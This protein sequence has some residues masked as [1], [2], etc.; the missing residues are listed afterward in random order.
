MRQK[1][2]RQMIELNNLKNLS[3]KQKSLLSE[4]NIR[5][6]ESKQL[7]DECSIEVKTYE[8]LVQDGARRLVEFERR[9]KLLLGMLTKA[10]KNV[11]DARRS[12][13]EAKLQAKGGHAEAS[14]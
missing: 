2:L 11:L 3:S 1:Q 5:L 6:N 13:N 14:K 9:H 7:L 12:L 4:Q 10:T 8:S